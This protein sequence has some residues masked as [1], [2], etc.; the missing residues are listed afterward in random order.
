MQPD[1]TMDLD[2]L[3][4]RAV[5]GRRFDVPLDGGAIIVTLELPTRHASKLA[6]SR[7]GLIEGDNTSTTMI[8]WTRSVLLMAVVAWT[9]VEERHVLPDGSH[10]QVSFAADA[11]DLLLDAQPQWEEALAAALLDRLAQRRAREDTA[12]KN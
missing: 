3:R 5:A 7:A 2:T 4:R 10:G 12:A 8:R 11:V 6:Y 1:S 9:G